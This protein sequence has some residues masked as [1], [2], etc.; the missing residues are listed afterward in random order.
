MSIRL[1][2]AVGSIMMA[3]VEDLP[4]FVNRTSQEENSTGRIEVLKMKNLIAGENL[5]MLIAGAGSAIGRR[6]LA[7]MSACVYAE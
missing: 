5:K 2:F 1:S 6:G 3:V 7:V 4:S